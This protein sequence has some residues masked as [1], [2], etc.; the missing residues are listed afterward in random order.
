MNFVCGEPRSTDPE[1]A[2]PICLVVYLKP[3]G[4]EIQMSVVGRMSAYGP[5]RT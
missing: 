3:N 2:A 4:A 1:M 5:K